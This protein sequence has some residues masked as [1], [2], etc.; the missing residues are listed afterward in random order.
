MR[1]VG[2]KGAILA[3]VVSTRF[4]RK[5]IFATLSLAPLP[6]ILEKLILF[7]ERLVHS[8]YAC[9]QVTFR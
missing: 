6:K 2:T 1:Y 5:A 4:T 8:F 9:G 7:C 3:S